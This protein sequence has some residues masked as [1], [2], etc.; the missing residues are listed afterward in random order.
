MRSRDAGRDARG[1]GGIIHT[2]QGYDPKN[3]PPP[4]REPPD[5]VSGA[6]EHMLAFGSTRRLTEEETAWLSDR[7]SDR[8]PRHRW[9]KAPSKRC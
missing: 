8:G 6:F 3:F 4:T 2:Y 7:F 1:L 9:M 5:M